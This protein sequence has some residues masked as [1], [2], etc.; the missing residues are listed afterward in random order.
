MPAS[1][2]ASAAACGF[3]PG[4]VRA[5][6]EQHE[7]RRD[8]LRFPG[9][10]GV[11]D[12]DAEPVAPSSLRRST[13]PTASKTASPIAVPPPPSSMP[14]MASR[15]ASWSRVAGARTSALPA[16]AIAPTLNVSGISATKDSA[17]DLAASSRFGSTS[18]ACIEPDVSIATM[19][20]ARSYGTRTSISGRARGEAEG[21][22]ARPGRAPRAGADATGAASGRACR[23]SAGSR[24]AR[25]TDGVG[26]G[27][28]GTPRRAPR[29]APGRAENQGVRKVIG[30]SV[31]IGRAFG[32]GG[33]MKR[34]SSRPRSSSVRRTRWSAPAARTAV[35]GGR[36]VGGCSGGVRGRGAARS[37][38]ATTRWAPDSGSTKT[39]SPTSGRSS[40]RGSSTST[41]T[42]SWR[43][44]SRRRAGSHGSPAL[45]VA[46]WSSR[47][48]DDDPQT[49]AAAPGRRT[50]GALRPGRSSGRRRGGR[51]IGT[52]HTA[53]RWS[54]PA[55]GG[56]QRIR[57]GADDA[58][59]RP[60]HPRRVVSR[61]IGRRRPGGD[62]APSH[63]RWCRRPCS[64]S[65]RP[66]PTSRGRA[67]RG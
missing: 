33:G 34:V 8:A 18:S 24:S 67:Q 47:S 56:V 62:I 54:R 28:A 40:S 25:R 37:E 26:A 44:D 9:P 12:G 39:T 11:G 2:A 61:P 20:V 57:L 4:G 55:P 42:T 19:T 50:R 52:E 27:R 63:G 60:G 23:A 6:G 30:S 17:A 64:A 43:A 58:E 14:A 66:A 41:T 7:S 31:P 32:A 1:R 16:K 48:R 5:V 13:S 15:T 46:D 53:R 65:G 3:A 29:P 10:A 21:G 35:G 36:A 59:S 38:V 45:S 22:Q 51:R 49:A